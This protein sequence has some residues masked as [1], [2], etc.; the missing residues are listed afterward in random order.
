LNEYNAGFKYN[1]FTEDL[2][3]YKLSN[4][5]HNLKSLLP[6]IILTHRDLDLYS[7][8]QFNVELGTTSLEQ[9]FK[10]KKAYKKLEEIQSTM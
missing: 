8:H 9:I 1:Q 5:L 3:M 10:H 4:F 2:V 6:V 7:L